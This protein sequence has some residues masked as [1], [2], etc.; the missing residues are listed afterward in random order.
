MSDIRERIMNTQLMKDLTSE[1]DES[2]LA[3]LDVWMQEN[4]LPLQN[5]IVSM[6]D[7]IST[8]ESAESLLDAINHALSPE[9]K[10]ELDSCLEKNSQTS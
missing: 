2:Q 8:S 3:E 1:L 5:I 10:E 6:G 4:I 9:G 7:M